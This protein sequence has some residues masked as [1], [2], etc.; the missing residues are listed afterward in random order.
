MG[1]R[2]RNSFLLG[3]AVLAVAVVGAGCGGGDD[4]STTAADTGTTTQMSSSEPSTI[5]AAAQATPE[6]STLVQAVTAA[7][8]VQ[9]LSGPG[10]FT[11]FAPTNAAFDA[12]PAGQLNELLKPAN[13]DQLTDILTYHVVKGEYTASDLTNGQRLATVEG[14]KLT[15]TVKGSIVEVDGVPVEMADVMTGNGVVHVIGSVL[16][17]PKT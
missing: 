15:V 5:V 9:T 1:S 7:D 17:P 4:D 16:T 2:L 8:L 10:P 3:A 6:L 14:G 11:V 13:K 12:L